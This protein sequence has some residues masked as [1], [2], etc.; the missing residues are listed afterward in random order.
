M[1]T[2]ERPTMSPRT[3]NVL[4]RLRPAT[5]AILHRLG[6]KDEMWA[7]VVMNRST[8]D[9]VSQLRPE[10]L[11][12]LEIS[13]DAWDGALPFAS[14]AKVGYPDFDIC[15]S[16]LDDRFD[17]VIAEQVFEH[18]RWPYRAGRHVYDMLNPGGHF[19]VTTPFLLRVH[20][21][22]LDCSRWTEQGMRHLL[23]E[24]GFPLELTKSGSWG[25]RRCVRKNFSHWAKY[26][27]GIHSLENE[28]DFPVVVWALARRP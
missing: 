14:Y 2:A 20:D 24:C 26:W 11:S 27:P 5:R 15:E 17:L 28:P 13:G 19:L 18:L 7:R 8:R 9:L 10:E 12:V 23:A 16:A 3:S 21:I 6:R 25:N 1:R 4:D 22:P